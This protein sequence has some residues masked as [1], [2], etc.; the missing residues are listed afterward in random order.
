MSPFL[1]MYSIS[2]PWS[3]SMAEGVLSGNEVNLICISFP[4]DINCKSFL[5]KERGKTRKRER[6]KE[7]KSE[8][9]KERVKE[10]KSERKKERVK[11]RKKE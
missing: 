4:E 7:R 8:R 5:F 6:K 3:E 11:E 10:R 2:N 9:K 1:K